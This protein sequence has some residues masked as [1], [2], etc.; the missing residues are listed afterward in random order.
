MHHYYFTK[1]CP[2]DCEGLAFW[3]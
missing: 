1:A 3:V 2:I